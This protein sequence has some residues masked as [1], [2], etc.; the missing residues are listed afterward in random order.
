MK[1][2]VSFLLASL[3]VTVFVLSPELIA[4]FPDD[5]RIRNG[6]DYPGY[7][8]R[9]IELPNADISECIEACR[10][11]S[12]CR[13]CTLVKPGIQGPNARCWLKDRIPA[14]RRDNCCVSAIKSRSS[15]RR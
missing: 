4:A 15:I 6:R 8:Y 13:V 11:D 2:S 12:R 3:T 7:D 10:R 9:S 5:F 1:A 14:S